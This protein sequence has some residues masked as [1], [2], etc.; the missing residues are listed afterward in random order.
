M[1][2]F[3]LDILRALQEW[4][5]P[6]FTF[7]FNFFTLFGE[8][9]I[10]IAVIGFIYWCKNKETGKKIGITVLFSICVNNI[11]KGIFMVERPKEIEGIKLLKP[12]TATGTSFPSG[13][14]QSASA[15][16]Y[17]IAFKLKRKWFYVL[18]TVIVLLVMLSRLYL[19]CHFPLDVIVGALLGFIIAFIL[20][21]VFDKVKNTNL[22][23]IVLI[24]IVTPFIFIFKSDDAFKMYGAITGT[25]LGF[26]IEERFVKFTQHKI[27]WK[28][29]VRLILGV[30]IAFGLLQTKKLL[31]LEPFF[32]FIRYFVTTLIAI[33]IYP[34]LFKMLKI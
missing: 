29:S 25:V 13:H 22:L 15:V 6:A 4:I 26:F 19:G 9:L 28:N 10:A 16:F 3:Q 8:E 18:S 32:Y 23:F 33:A 12:S 17:S 30:L 14:S 27:I 2:E 24:L 31:P 5:N 20:S 34:M 1:R 11:L 21:K 7:I